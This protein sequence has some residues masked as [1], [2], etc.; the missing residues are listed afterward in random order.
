MTRRGGL[1]G[2]RGGTE[3]RAVH[4]RG[5]QGGVACAERA[6]VDGKG[7]VAQDQRGFWPGA[8][9]K[10]VAAWL[11]A[12]PDRHGGVGQ[13]QDYD[14]RVERQPQIG[15]VGGGEVRRVDGAGVCSVKGHAPSIFEAR[16]I[17]HVGPGGEWGEGFEKGGEA[18]APGEEDRALR[19]VRFRKEASHGGEEFLSD[20]APDDRKAGGQCLGQAGGDVVAIDGETAGDLFRGMGGEKGRG[21]AALQRGGEGGDGVRMRG[22]GGGPLRRGLPR[23][24]RPRPAAR[25]SRGRHC[26]IRPAWAGGRCGR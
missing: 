5:D 9:G 14:R 2:Q 22:Q 11:V 19:A 4:E 21:W 24:V 1:G 18:V 10:V 15:G 3:R 20:K 23:R 12:G 16:D 8:G 17:G 26:P 25:A 6:D 7:G 13:A